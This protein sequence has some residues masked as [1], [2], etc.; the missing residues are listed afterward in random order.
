[1]TRTPDETRDASTA[2]AAS[3][4]AASS[5]DAP[6]FAIGS[7]VGHRYRLVRLIAIG[8]MGE[9]Y[10]A[11]DLELGTRV[12]VKTI[13]AERGGDP[14]AA[15]RLKQEILAARKVTHPNVVR[16]FDVG[17][18]VPDDG[19]DVA[20]FTMELLDGE[21]LAGRIA[22]AGRLSAADAL[23]L[24]RQLA[25]ALDAA[26][27]AGIVHRD[28]KSQN[29]ILV[30]DRAIVTDFGLA[31]GNDGADT[32]ATVDVVGTPA[33]MAPEQVTRSTRIGPAA[34]VYAFG[35][36]LFEM[37]TG[38]WPF[39]RETALAT[40]AA[41][42]VEPAPS[43]RTRVRDLPAAWDAAIARCLRRDPAHRFARCGDV[44]AALERGPRRGNRAIVGLGL[45]AT[46][47]AAA[48]GAAHVLASS[49]T[50]CARP[51]LPDLYVDAGA[52]RGGNGSRG[53]PFRTISA[54]AGVD[55]ERRVVH[56]GPGFYD[57]A[58]GEEFPL[59]LRGETT[60]VGAGMDRT[61]IAG[62]GTADLSAAEGTAGHRPWQAS[63][64]VGDR[65]KSIV[66]EDLAVTS[67]LATIHHDA[68]GILC[69]RGRA[70]APNTKLARVR[71]GGG[72]GTGL[73]VATETAPSASACNVDV[74]ETR[75]H[76]GYQGVWQVGCG[77]GTGRVPTGVTVRDSA[78]VG[79]RGN[80]TFAGTG[81]GVWDCVGSFVV[82]RSSFTDSDSGI[83]LVR[84]AAVD[85]AEAVI[86]DN[87]FD[88]LERAGIRLSLGARARIENNRIQ[89]TGGVGAL[90]GRA[91]GLQLQLEADEP[92]QVVVRGNRF[93]END[94]GVELIGGGPA[95][96]GARL[97]LGRPDDPGDNLFL[98]NS[99]PD[100]A[101]SPGGDVVVRVA[102][103]PGAR[104]D[105]AGNRWDHDP[106]ATAAEA[107]N[108]L[109]I[110]VAA[111]S[112][113]A[114]D[115]SAARPH[116]GGCLQRRP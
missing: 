56:V 73:V 22:R 53:C 80:A 13:R 92:A 5:P 52:A 24:A 67:G 88:G 102:A 33:Y 34:D 46:L 48:L 89:S 94:I 32:T 30:G 45:V 25:A 63:L 21:T 4:R 49:P 40:A 64:L 11:E 70:D 20:F 59:V 15:A 71:L 50:A 114:I 54:A 101:P 75:F 19:C 112:S 74:S 86:R 113:L 55:A 87:A 95:P 31:R 37:V 9:V 16:L 82:E 14:G 43:P 97:D 108:G 6:R 17:F 7:V 85:G 99:S 12:A 96:A 47:A 69:T 81:I 72:Y 79:F 84:H 109:E 8:G 91:A 39:R 62:V 36:V 26:H 51:T 2:S 76:D 111:G 10:E 65:A 105:L 41:R 93:I 38:E 83:S 44:I 28:F 27:A 77:I 103:Q 18:H 116:G 110:W 3:P 78:F 98:C 58:H 100:A 115:A 107:R 104:L 57:R 68:V 106:P 60:L 66:I 42:V 90:I 61:T 29:V 23:P 1:M 35:V